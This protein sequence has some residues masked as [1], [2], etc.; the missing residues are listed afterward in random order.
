MNETKIKYQQK[1][2]D[3]FLDKIFPIDPHAIVAGGAVRDWYFGNPA[4]DIDLFFHVRN[5]VTQTTV[6]KMLKSIGIN[7]KEKKSCDNI[8][9]WYKK[10]PSIVAVYD[11]EYNSQKIQLIYMNESTFNCVVKKFPVSICKAWRK[12][13]NNYYEEDFKLSCMYSTIWKTS[14]LYNDGDKFIQKIKEKFPNF[15]Y[16]DEDGTLNFLKS[17][18]YKKNPYAALREKAL[19][20]YYMSSSSKRGE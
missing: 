18:E 8:P 12:G 17:W 14:E 7:V 3:L 19:L 6:E 15:T 13:G 11:V 2:A 1:V 16:C 10:N 5:N 4:N 20:E 9:D